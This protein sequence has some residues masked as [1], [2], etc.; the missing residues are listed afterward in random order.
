MRKKILLLVSII[1]AWSLLWVYVSNSDIKD[2]AEVDAVK[3]QV[4]NPAD[5]WVREDLYYFTNN[6]IRRTNRLMELQVAPDRYRNPNRIRIL[7]LGDSYTA[8][9]G[10][11]SLDSVWWRQLEFELDAS[12]ADGTFE[13]VALGSGG[14]S[15]YTYAGWAQAIESGIYNTVALPGS[16][17][18]RLRENFDVVVLGYVENDIIANHDDSFIAEQDRPPEREEPRPRGVTTGEVVNPH[19]SYFES[20][21][22]VIKAAFDAPLNIW[23]PLTGSNPSTNPEFQWGSLFESAGWVLADNPSS[24]DTQARFN[25]TDLMVTPIDPHPGPR[26]HLSFAKDAARSL[27]ENIDPDRLIAATSTAATTER[28]ALSGYLPANLDLQEQGNGWV[29]AHD[30]T[31]PPICVDAAAARDHGVKCLDGSKFKFFSNGNTY[32]PQ[33]VGCATINQPHVQ[34]MFSRSSIPLSISLTAPTVGDLEAWALTINTDG[35]LGSRLLAPLSNTKVV[36]PPETRGVY[37][38]SSQTG[39]PLSNLAVPP[40]SAFIEFSQS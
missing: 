11:T 27:L 2:K 22:G 35:S 31:V 13:V 16:D 18:T 3:R 10:L 24:R 37:I 28:S 8:G 25:D 6:M 40:F 20:A 1:L 32:D 7:V 26:R 19:Q 39:C 5:V 15:L 34:V 12:T 21:P 9:W 23:L 36:L 14:A 33:W 30:G 17:A 38:A 4:G 29:V